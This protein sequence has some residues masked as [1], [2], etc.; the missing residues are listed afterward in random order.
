MHR[1]RWY[2]VVRKGHLKPAR[3]SSGLVV[4]RHLICTSFD[5]AREVSAGNFSRLPFSAVMLAHNPVLAFFKRLAASYDKLSYTNTYSVRILPGRS[6]EPVA[7]QPNEDGM[8][9]DPSRFPSFEYTRPPTPEELRD[10]LAGRDRLMVELLDSGVPPDELGVVVGCQTGECGGSGCFEELLHVR[11]LAL[12]FLL[13]ENISDKPIVLRSLEALVEAPDGVGFRRL[14]TLEAELSSLPLP[15]AAIPSGGCALIPEV[16]LLEPIEGQQFDTWSSRLSTPACFVETSRGGFSSES[17]ASYRCIGPRL[18]VEALTLQSG[19][20]SVFRE[21]VHPL[22]LGNTYMLAEGLQVGSCPH[23][24][25]LSDSGKPALYLGEL[26]SA[27]AGEER[28]VRST[29]RMPEGYS[30]VRVAELENEEAVIT[31]CSSGPTQLLARPMSLRK[32]EHVDLRVS[33]PGP[34]EFTGWYTTL[35]RDRSVQ[36]LWKRNNLVT[37]YLFTLA[38]RRPWATQILHEQGRAPV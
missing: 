34:I 29:V 17:Q 4:A 32:G 26:F 10:T 33:A 1:D 23:V 38:Q 36:A 5:I 27:C 20:D 22:D 13:V 24:F 16:A 8:M 11:S 15:A 3:G 28:L 19:S 9:A 25:A 31:S 2:E 7:G 18:E 14:T 21:P 6:R 30:T 35:A 37:E 12:A